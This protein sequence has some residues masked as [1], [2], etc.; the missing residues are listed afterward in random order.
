MS[1]YST[2]ALK[3]GLFFT[4]S[5]TSWS[6][7]IVG[8]PCD[9]L[10]AATTSPVKQSYT[11]SNANQKDASVNF[12][13][14]GD[15]TVTLTVVGTDGQTH[16]CTW[17]QHVVG[18]GVRFEL[19]WD[20]TGT[21]RQGGADLDLHVHRSGTTKPWFDGNDDCFYNNCAA[22]SFSPLCRFG[23]CLD[24]G[25]A[26]S[27]LAQ[28]QG[29]GGWSSGCH[30]PRLDIDNISTVGKPEN[31]NIDV[32]KNGDSFRAMVHYFGQDSGTSSTP[33]E[34]HPIVNIYCGGVL[35]ATYGQAPD[36]VSGFDN[37]T[38]GKKGQMWRVADVKAQVDS[39]GRTTDCDIT[40]IHPPGMTDGY[41]VTTDDT[42]Y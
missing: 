38:G 34:E 42:S 21:G 25:Y 17:V 22:A 18:P 27:P 19:C 9:Q 23:G 13:L 14:S 1:P 24:W 41:Y 8:G 40:A 12:T 36:T 35:K 39:S 31:T 15:Y 7:Q 29:A 26:D 2:L 30:N 6:W 32:P 16:T 20:H 33:V 3:G 10:F 4:G 28:C 37:G 5:A 11:L